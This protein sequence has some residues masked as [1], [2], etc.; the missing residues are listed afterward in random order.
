MMRAPRGKAPQTRTD[1]FQAKYRANP[2]TGC[3]E[4]T[5]ARNDCGYGRF[6]VSGGR[7][8]P[9]HRFSYEMSR[10]RIPDGLIVCHHCDNPPCVNPDHLFLGTHADNFAD[11]VRKGRHLPPPH[12]QGFRHPRTKVSAE[13]VNRIRALY[14]EGAGSQRIL[15]RSFGLSQRTVARIV[16]R[17]SFAGG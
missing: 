6:S 2:V 13:I 7:T 14:A 10:G 5:A 3:W 4:W 17:I 12:P 16:N 1:W 11:A 8:V 9:A 15:G